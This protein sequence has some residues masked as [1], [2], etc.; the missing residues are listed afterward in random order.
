MSG[1]CRERGRREWGRVRGGCRGR[2]EG[3]R[4]GC[5]KRGRRE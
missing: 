2:E 3:V 4:G 5:R 1:G